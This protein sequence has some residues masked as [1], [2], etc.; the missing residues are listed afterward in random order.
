V[1]QRFGSGIS[2]LV[3][4]SEGVKREGTDGKRK[5][6]MVIKLDL[7][8]SESKKINPVFMKKNRKS[9]NSSETI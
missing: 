7:K 2:A 3:L 6:D 5:M 8:N 1:V 9:I 4:G